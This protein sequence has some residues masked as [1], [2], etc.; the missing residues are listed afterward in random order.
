VAD[1]YGAQRAA[2]M[3]EHMARFAAEFEVDISVPP[4]IPC[5]RRALAMTEFAR[6]RDALV[7]LRDAIMKA[8][9]ADRRDIED[10]RVLGELAEQVGLDPAAALA[11]ADS[12]RYRDRLEQARQ[13]ALQR[14]VHGIPT[15][16]FGETR[17]VGCQPYPTLRAIAQGQGWPPA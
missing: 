6:D 2:A 4:R 7:E 17:V 11:A 15:F 14:Q 8:H 3:A 16:F 9:W 1:R 12:E 5:T 10:D 13:D